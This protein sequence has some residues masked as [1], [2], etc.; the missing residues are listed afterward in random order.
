MAQ[1]LIEGSKAASSSKPLQTAG[2]QDCVVC[3][4]CGKH[5]LVTETFRC[6]VCG[7]DHIC[8]SHFSSENLSC[9]GCAKFDSTVGEIRRAGD[10]KVLKL[11]G[12]FE[13][14]MVWCPP[15]EFV[16]G[17]TRLEMKAQCE[18]RNAEYRDPPQKLVRFENGFWMGKY[19]VT[20]AQWT[21]VMGDN[22]SKFRG[23]CRPV[24]TVTWGACC[25]FCR[26]SGLGLRL[27]TE[28]EWEYACR[29]GSRTAYCWG[30]ALNGDRANCDGCG[31]FGTREKG[32]CVGETTCVGSY[33]AGKNAWGL[34]D[35]HGNVWEWCSDNTEY[36]RRNMK[37]G[38]DPKSYPHVCRGGSW[39]TPAISCTSA[40]P[41]GG[42][43]SDA[44][45][46][47]GFRVCCSAMFMRTRT[48]I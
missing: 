14:E 10:V 23:E 8:L 43:A 16:M 18:C 40:C 38:D 30:D 13:I 7:K 22:P 34:Y 3:P 15:G 35:M 33:E 11:P 28:A 31:P 2:A 21:S 6:K 47:I 41:S 12:G 32:P 27:P 37:Q 26:K 46:D 20:Q 42:L 25:D 44:Y 39:Y 45:P 19:E 29:A 1:V 24:E 9:T 5:N 48:A 17:L 4:I 36:A